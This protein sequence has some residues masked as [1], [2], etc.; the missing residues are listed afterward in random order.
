[1]QSESMLAICVLMLAAAPATASPVGEQIFKSRCGVCHWDPAAAGEKPR[2]GPSLRQLIGRRAGSQAD[3]TRYSA[4]MKK[5]DFGWTAD[6]LDSFLNDPRKIVPGTSMA[7]AGLK[8][9][10]ERKAV[11][12]YL[13]RTGR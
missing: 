1:M 6:R 12:E 5:A 2:Q 3:F 10:D 13:V 9:P 7:F 11:V 4:A 8:K